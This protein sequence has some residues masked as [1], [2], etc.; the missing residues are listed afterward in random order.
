M[1][2]VQVDPS[3]GSVL[4]IEYR[5]GLPWGK[6]KTFQRD[7]HQQWHCRHFQATQ[8]GRSVVGLWQVQGRSKAWALFEGERIEQTDSFV[9]WCFSS[10]R[11]AVGATPTS[12]MA[13]TCLNK[14]RMIQRRWKGLSN[15]R[16]INYS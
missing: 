2:Q 10:N 16:E 9:V 1:K 13:P 12:S 7:C 4:E 15:R 14:R 6:I 11:L 3:D 8:R 5:N